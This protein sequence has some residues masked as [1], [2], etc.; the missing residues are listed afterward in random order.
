MESNMNR[1]ETSAF[2]AVLRPHVG[3]LS[4][5]REI[6]CERH[7]RVVARF[8]YDLRRYELPGVAL[9]AASSVGFGRSRILHA[10]F[11]TSGLKFFVRSG[12]RIL[13][14]LCAKG[15][16]RGF[17]DM[18]ADGQGLR[19][20]LKLIQGESDKGEPFMVCWGDTNCEAP[21]HPLK[22]CR[23]GGRQEVVEYP[24]AGCILRPEERIHTIREWR[25][26]AVEFAFAC[27][28]YE[29]LGDGLM[30]P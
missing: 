25:K 17:L 22:N 6:V 27:L 14:C 20:F 23:R 21:V 9:D 13:Q 28:E 18:R 19:Y 3:T 8:A 15:A 16:G 30:G 4:D 11:E 24:V 7:H 5:G 1:S 12:S 10:E 2:N 29:D 26:L